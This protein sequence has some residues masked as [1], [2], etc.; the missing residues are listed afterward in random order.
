[1]GQLPSTCY[2]CDDHDPDTIDSCDAATLTC[3]NTP[4]KPNIRTCGLAVDKTSYGVGEKAVWNITSDPSGLQAYWYGTGIDPAGR[5][6]PAGCS[7]NP[8]PAA[9]VTPYTLS[10]Y[11]FRAE[12]VGT[13]QR[14]AKL[15][16]ASGHDLCTTNTLSVTVAPVSCTL[17]VDKTSYAVG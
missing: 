14:F 8:C 12:D 17:T 7:T 11:A 15:R 4:I 9:Q 16:D 3:K 1:D 13:F 10:D 5:G 2:S 6:I